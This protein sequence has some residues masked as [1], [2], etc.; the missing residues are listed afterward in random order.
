MVKLTIANSG[1][2]QFVYMYP[3]AFVRLSDEQGYRFPVVPTP[4]AVPRVGELVPTPP[5]K[6]VLR[7]QWTSLMILPDQ[8]YTDLLVFELGERGEK[9]G[10]GGKLLLDLPGDVFQSDGKTL[11]SPPDR[12]KRIGW[13]IDQSAVTFGPEPEPAP[14]ATNAAK[15]T[16]PAKGG[17]TA[18]RP[19]GTGR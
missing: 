18:K 3:R 6:F 9:L 5:G 11:E 4:A 8:R 13:K 17:R 12:P 1:S 10:Q 2:E 7:G 16:A 15:G 19:T 14:A